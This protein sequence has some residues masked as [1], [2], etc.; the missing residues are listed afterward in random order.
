M[1]NNVRAMRFLAFIVSS[2]CFFSCAAMQVKATEH[3]KMKL[4]V[5]SVGKKTSRLERVIAQIQKDFS[6]TKQFAVSLDHAPAL[7]KNDD[8]K[9]FFQAGFPLVLFVSK[10]AKGTLEWR[11]YDTQRAV[12][13]VGKI[14]TKRGK[15]PE[16]WGHHIADAVWPVLT[17]QPGF[18]STKIA[19]CKEVRRKGRKNLMRIC[20]ADFDGSHEKEFET[21]TVNVSPRWS[22]TN[23]IVCS[24]HANNKVRLISIDMTGKRTVV[25]DFDGVN[26]QAAF[27]PDGKRAV[28]SSSRG[29][30]T[31]QLYLYEQGNLKKL[32]N[33]SGNN[34]G[35]SFSDDAKTLFFCS[36]YQTG[37]P[38]IYRYEFA[39]G[40]TERITDGGFCVSP[41]YCQSND[42]VAYSKMVGG[43]MQIFVYDI[44]AKTHQQVT[45]SAGNK[46][47]CS[48]SPCGN[49]LLFSVE[50]GKESRL[51]IFNRITK[52]QQFITA[53]GSV[54]CY[55][56]WSAPFYEFP[57]S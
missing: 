43:T 18:F 3:A 56:S 55:P 40:K 7:V 23:K 11:L 45:S 37:S 25:S 8:V 32:T 20:Y 31:C 44:K 9:L 34:I 42:M 6:F 14:Y 39:T 46:D 12:M 21:Q 36:D 19:Y 30:S 47:D 35:P 48:W 52:D 15:S 16:A 22:P 51:A 24:E 49:Y 33:N 2:C 53:K 27:S 10:G 28:F 17:G 38:Q 13:L 4:N 57:V 26:M 50:M 1:M 54:C 41:C 29:G 5:C